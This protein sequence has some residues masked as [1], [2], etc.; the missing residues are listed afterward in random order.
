M[1]TKA[2]LESSLRDLELYLQ[3]VE[4]DIE[5]LRGTVIYFEELMSDLKGDE[6]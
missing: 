5:L 6:E 2:E 3:D 4:T 1:A